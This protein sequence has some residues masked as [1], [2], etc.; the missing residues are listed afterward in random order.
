MNNK[1]CSLA[2]VLALTAGCSGKSLEL[3]V[4]PAQVHT[5]AGEGLSWSTRAAMDAYMRYSVWSGGRSG[6]VTMFARDGHPVYA[7]AVGWA[8]IEGQ[9]PMQLDTR[10]RFASMTKPITAVAAMILVEE[11][12]LN[13]DD[14]VAQY[15]PAFAPPRVAT[16]E[17]MN[18]D[19]SFATE[20]AKTVPLVRHLLMFSSGVGP[21]MTKKSDLKDHWEANGLWSSKGE[22]LSERVDRIVQLPLFEEPGSK[23]RYGGSADVLARVVEVAAGKPF[24]V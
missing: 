22:S 2:L 3:T 17:T 11:G 15:I 20:P 13:L 10:M 12:R 14:P 4:P 9:V 18:A 23:W 1:F 16:S 19:G 6:F 24:D 5:E 21:G 7:N 8:D